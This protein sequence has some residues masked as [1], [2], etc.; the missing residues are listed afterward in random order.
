MVPVSYLLYEGHTE[1]SAAIAL[2]MDLS[3]LWPLES[4]TE[5]KEEF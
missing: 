2:M 1:L 4:Q 3:S 5:F